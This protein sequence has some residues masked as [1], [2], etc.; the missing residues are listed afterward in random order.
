V[1]RD[2]LDLPPRDAARAA[3][4]VALRTAL[5]DWI[6]ATNRRDLARQ[7]DFYPPTLSV[8]YRERNVS[9]AAVL[10][11]KRRLFARAET[12]DVKA[13]PPDIILEGP[14]AATMR[15]RKTY[16]IRGPQTSRRG[17]VIQELRWVKTPSGWKITGE[18]DSEVIR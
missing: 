9:R 16:D 4:R 14:G 15:F 8:F 11:E 3:D 7:M 2:A 12:V 6:A 10:A 18:R 1:P 13:G 17:E 5:D